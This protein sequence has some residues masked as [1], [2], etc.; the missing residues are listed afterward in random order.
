MFAFVCPPL[1]DYFLVPIHIVPNVFKVLSPL[2][3]CSH[4][5]LKLLYLVLMVACIHSKPD[6]Q[7]YRDLTNTAQY[8][9]EFGVA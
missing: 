1:T 8:K 4:V 6:S 3:F 5:E 2:P 9:L 7:Q